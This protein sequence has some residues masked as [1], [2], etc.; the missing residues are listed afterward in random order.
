MP[1]MGM[2]GQGSRD[3]VTC[4]IDAGVTL[5]RDE[6]GPVSNTGLHPCVRVSPPVRCGDPEQP[7]YGARPCP[8]RRPDAWARE[9][10]PGAEVFAWR[11]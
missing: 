8:P 3:P 1:G 9:G 5:D 4:R 6:Q 2:P 11:R 10:P 7:S